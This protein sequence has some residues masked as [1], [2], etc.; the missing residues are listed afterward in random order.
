MNYGKVTMKG[1]RF[2]LFSVDR[3][4]PKCDQPQRHPDK[5][6]HL[7]LQNLKPAPYLCDEGHCQFLSFLTF[8]FFTGKMWHL[9]SLKYNICNGSPLFHDI[10]SKQII[11]LYHLFSHN[12]QQ[13]KNYNCSQSP[14][15]RA[16]LQAWKKWTRMNEARL[17]FKQLLRL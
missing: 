3:L 12:F 10:N 9:Q 13:K 7:F 8:K 14:K 4:N 6:L 5:H 2:Q 1:Q 17:V 11:L 16:C 15:P